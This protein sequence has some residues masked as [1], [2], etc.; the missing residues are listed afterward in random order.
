VFTLNS[1]PN[2]MFKLFQNYT[3]ISVT[4]KLN[5]TSII[6]LNTQ[7]L[8]AYFRLNDLLWQEGFFI[9]F[10]QKKSFDKFLKK[11]L[12]FSAYTFS[13]RYVFDKVTKFYI[14]LILWFSTKQSIYEFNNIANTLMIVVG[15]ISTL[16]LTVS[17][18]S[19]ANMYFFFKP[20]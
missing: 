9:D 15:L 1:T 8:S 11:F 2:N 18:L 6:L 19:I 4:E 5:L 13:E 7:F 17:F 20:F 3:R 16:I 12:I 14:D 10:V